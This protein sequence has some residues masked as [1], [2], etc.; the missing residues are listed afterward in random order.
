[1][2]KLQ[3]AIL[4]KQQFLLESMVTSIGEK[5]IPE[6]VKE[7]KIDLIMMGTVG[8]TGI[9]GFIMDRMIILRQMLH[10]LIYL[11]S[12][13]VACIYLSIY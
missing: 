8:R 2:M 9:P 5:Q 3:E 11:R 6:I 4:E 1:M 13:L 12:W 10:R 7:Q